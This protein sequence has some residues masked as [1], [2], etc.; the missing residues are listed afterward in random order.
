MLC[1]D[2]EVVYFIFLINIDV[3]SLEKKYLISRVFGKVKID[4]LINIFLKDLFYMVF[5][6]KIIDIYNYLSEW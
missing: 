1:W 2:N 5:F 3:M 4:L 6:F